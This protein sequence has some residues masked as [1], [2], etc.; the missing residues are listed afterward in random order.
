[1][2]V[3]QII[4]LFCF[5]STFVQAQNKFRN[6]YNHFSI[7][8][9]ATDKWTD[10]EEGDNT[11]VFNSND[12]GDII[13][14]RANGDIIVF[15]KISEAKV[16]YLEKSYSRYQIVQVLDEDGYKCQIQLFDD[17]KKGLKII[18]SNVMIQFAR[19]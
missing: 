18:Y 7:F 6:D 2:K 15:K 8:N 3:F 19:L 17:E 4:L 13:H 16:D 5:S 12:N 11:F 10:W 14:Y 1:M 9:V